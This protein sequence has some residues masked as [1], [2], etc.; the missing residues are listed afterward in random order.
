MGLR[1]AVL[2]KQVPRVE[3]MEL[4]PGGVLRRD[5]LD[6]EM[7]A[8]CRRAVSTASFISSSE[9]VGCAPGPAPQR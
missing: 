4:G 5:G 7:N 9:N 2:I 1:I 8:Y 6:L 3:E